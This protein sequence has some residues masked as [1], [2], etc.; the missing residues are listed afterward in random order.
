MH[1]GFSEG[2]SVGK[3]PL[4]KPRHRWE[5]GTEMDL[6]EIGWNYMDCV[7]LAQDGHQWRALV[8]TVMNHRVPNI[9]GSGDRDCLFL[10]GQSE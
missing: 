4:E 3:R 7:D 2:A 10:L 1:V 5:Y 9:V 8:N 6:R